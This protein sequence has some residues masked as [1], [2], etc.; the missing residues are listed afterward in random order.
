MDIFR[1]ILVRTFEVLPVEK[2]LP[3][4]PPEGFPWG[5]FWLI[6]GIVVMVALA[7]TK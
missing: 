4:K 5:W 3:E 2:K 7:N 1:V 6:V